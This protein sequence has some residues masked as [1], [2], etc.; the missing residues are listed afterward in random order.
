MVMREVLLHFIWQFRYFNQRDLFTEAG[1]TLLILSG[2]EPNHH[3]GPDFLKARIKI[4][5]VL[6]EGPVE[7]HLKTSDW[8]R[9]AHD[10]DL[11]Y[12]EVILHVVWEN[13]CLTPPGDIPILVLR[14]R[15]S[16]LLLGQYREWMVS[17]NFVPCERRLPEIDEDNWA[18][19]HRRLLLHRLRQ[20]S[21]FIRSCLEDNRQHWEET[22]W[23]MIA[24]SLGQ[25]IN[26]QAF[27]AIARS[28]PFGLLIRNRKDT[29]R[30]EALLLGQAGLLEDNYAEEYPATL[31][32]EYRFCRAKYKL[33][34][35]G[36][37][38]SFLRMRPGHFPTIRLVQLAHLLSLPPGWFALIREAESAR[39]LMDR[40]DIVVTGY[41]EDH[42]IP[43]QTSIIR[44]KRLGRMI[45]KSILINAFVPMLFAFGLLRKI[46]VYREKALRWLDET[47]PETNVVVN[48][49]GRLGIIAGTAAI[50]QSLLELKKGFCDP[51]RCLDCAVGQRLLG[52]N[53]IPEQPMPGSS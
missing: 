17:R 36:V 11:H 48:G 2:G 9:H 47:G 10:G 43:G 27:F 12:R 52:K 8:L 21:L 41:W 32:N 51:K 44:P 45:K 38:L 53:P 4:G 39:E 7:L 30:L 40:L 13:D 35:V 31:K 14:H 18:S 29:F 37:P 16:R 42:Y 28:L 6:R 33:N 24:R 26:G 23:W 19:W 46:P 25:P 3:Q 34:P 50:S 20:R 22:M 49:W 5:G 1:E 15:T